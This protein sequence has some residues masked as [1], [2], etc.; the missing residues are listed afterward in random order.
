MPELPEWQPLDQIGATVSGGKSN[1]RVVGIVASEAA[2]GGGWAEHAV[3]SLARAWS[4]AGQRVMLVDGALQEPALHTAAGVP[5]AEGLSDA[6][7]F[8][9]S[10]GRVTQ[11]VDDGAFLLIPA[12]TAIADTNEVV[13][14]RRWDQLSRGFVEAGV[15][16]GVFL[17]DG[18]S[19]TAAFL[20]SASEIVVLS[21]RADAPPTAVRDLEPLVS[22]VTGPDGAVDGG[23]GAVSVAASGPGAGGDHELSA[24]ALKATAVAGR[25]RM[26]LFFFLAL[27]LIVALLAAFGVLDIPGISSQSMNQAFLAGWASEIARAVG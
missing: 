4:S 8:G 27:V 3:L 6:T 1:G 20:G 22:L 17:R 5:N 15:T 16:L 24:S 13:R 25:S 19:G 12:G 7:L 9:A 11:Q 2:V 23:V 21:G 14:S 26:Y 18:D 10:V